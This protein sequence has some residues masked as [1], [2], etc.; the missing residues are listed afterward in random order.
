M[1]GAEPQRLSHV[2]TPEDCRLVPTQ[3][4]KAWLGSIF[5]HFPLPGPLPLEAVSAYPL[6]LPPTP[7][8]LGQ[9][10]PLGSPGPQGSYHLSTSPSGL[11]LPRVPLSLADS[12]AF[13][14]LQ[15]YPSIRHKTGKQ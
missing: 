1:E 5:T 3:G 12:K 2:G 6:S 4:C 7:T 13:A 14:S 8:R 15:R 10:L 9:G 11:S